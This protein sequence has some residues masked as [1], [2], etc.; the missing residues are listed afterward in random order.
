MH[1]GAGCFLK[2]ETS[3]SQTNV[4]GTKQNVLSQI[5][6]QA[7]QYIPTNFGCAPD[8]RQEKQTS[9][10]VV[11]TCRPRSKWSRLVVKA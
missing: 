9:P 6:A 3:R 11:A 1:V 5:T 4:K 2:E 8:P 7:Q 10:Q